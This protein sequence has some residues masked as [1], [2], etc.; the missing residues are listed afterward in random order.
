MNRDLFRG[1]ELDLLIG[2]A[3]DSA[4]CHLDKSTRWVPMTG[5]VLLFVGGLLCAR[6]KLIKD[7]RM[8]DR[9]RDKARGGS[10]MRK[11]PAVVG[12]A[13]L[14]GLSLARHARLGKLCPTLFF[15]AARR[16]GVSRRIARN[17]EFDSATACEAFLSLTKSPSPSTK[18][19]PRTRP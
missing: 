4:F 13:K 16:R 5:F 17:S 8:R 9:Q 12:T 6:V 2:F 15:S 3:I 11:S 19:S 18:T 14:R 7:A 1:R 10:A